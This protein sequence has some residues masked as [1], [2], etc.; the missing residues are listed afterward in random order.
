ML[1]QGISGIACNGCC[2][3]IKRQSIR[4]HWVNTQIS[5][6]DVN[7]RIV[8]SHRSISCQTR[9]RFYTNIINSRQYFKIDIPFS[10]PKLLLAHIVCVVREYVVIGIP[11]IVHDEVLKCRPAGSAGLISDPATAPPV[12][13]ATGCSAKKPLRYDIYDTSYSKTV[14][15]TRIAIVISTVSEPV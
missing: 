1:V 13:L 2:L 15:F 12:R 6:N 10:E 9:I 14:G 7:C 5:L 8:W 4:Q 3:I 11:E